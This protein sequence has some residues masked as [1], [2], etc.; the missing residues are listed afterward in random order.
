M[1]TSKVTISSANTG[2]DEHSKKVETSVRME[3]MRQDT[4]QSLL[5]RFNYHS[6]RIINATMGA[7][8]SARKGDMLL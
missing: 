4:L 8:E 7:P 3:S 6:L 2:K 5:Q 1:S